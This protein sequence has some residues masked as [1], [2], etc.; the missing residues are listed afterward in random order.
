MTA[1]QINRATIIS[2]L[3]ISVF[4]LFDCYVFPL[5]TSKGVVITKTESATSRLRVAIYR[6]QTDRN[7][8]TVPPIAYNK[9]NEN[10]TIV[11]GRSYITH[12]VQRVAVYK[13]GDSYS[14]RI[15][16]ISL[17]G[18]DFLVLLIVSN[19]VYLFFFYKKLK[20]VQ[21]RRDITI[22]L[23]FLTALFLLFYFLF[24]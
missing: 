4:L 19:A 1:D 24:E 18:F 17:G 23:S 20:K 22:F 16:F 7:L 2:L 5:D 10:D 13:K 3:G 9:I 14:W 6:I 8:L 15:G 12:A 11:V 21:T